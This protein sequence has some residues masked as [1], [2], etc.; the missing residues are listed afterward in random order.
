MAVWM[1]SY[2]EKVL[3]I[4]KIYYKTDSD[5]GQAEFSKVFSED[6]WLDKRIKEGKSNVYIYYAGHGAP[7]MKKNKAYLIPYDGD[8]NYASLTG[9]GMDVLY[10]N[11]GQMGSKSVT[12]F[13]DAC[14]SGERENA[15][16]VRSTSEI[17][18]QANLPCS[19]RRMIGCNGGPR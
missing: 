18:I 14:F 3:G 17:I 13:L 1:K 4:K 16:L 15:T 2:F 10:D 7:D 19:A 5:V 8:P 9:Y 6:G 12:V 11:L